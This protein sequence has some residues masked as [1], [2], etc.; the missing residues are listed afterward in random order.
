MLR[1]EQCTAAA[2]MVKDCGQRKSTYWI[3]SYLTRIR[4]A[5]ILQVCHS[6]LKFMA[7]SWASKYMKAFYYAHCFTPFCFN[8][9]W[10][11]T[12]LRNFCCRIF[13]LMPFG[14][15]HSIML[16]PYFW[17]DCHSWFMCTFQKHK[18][19]ALICLLFV[20]LPLERKLSAIR[21]AWIK[22]VNL[23]ILILLN[24]ICKI[25]DIKEEKSLNI[26]YS[27]FVG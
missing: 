21:S 5:Y 6:I 8:A 2:V 17:W 23:K 7:R 26:I 11:F 13:G 3:I 19:S 18:Y 1:Y 9:S 10:K 4:Q 15:L 22:Q 12:L 20:F 16:I 24:K 25:F 14:W 27:A